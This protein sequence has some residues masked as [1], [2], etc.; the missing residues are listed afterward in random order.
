[1]CQNHSRRACLK[2]QWVFLTHFLCIC[3]YFFESKNLDRISNPE[4][5]PSKDDI[6]LARIPT[7]GMSE[8]IISIPD[9]GQYRKFQIVDVGGQRSERSKWIHQFDIVTAVLFIASLSCYD[10]FLFEEEDVNAMYSITFCL[11]IL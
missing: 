11:Q 3:N 1:M 4:Y 6:L 5:L 7:T 2:K 9:N 8:Q 10:Q